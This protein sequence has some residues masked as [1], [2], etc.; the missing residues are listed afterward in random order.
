MLKRILWAAAL[1]V[2][3]AGMA[4]AEDRKTLE[5]QVH[6]ATITYDFSTLKRIDK[7]RVSIISHSVS[8]Q[9]VIDYRMRV[10][11]RLYAFCERPVGRY[12]APQEIMGWG[13]ASN[14]ITPVRV[15]QSGPIKSISWTY[16]YLEFSYRTFGR[17]RRM[18]Q[19]VESVPCV[20]EFPVAGKNLEDLRRWMGEG[21]KNFWVFDCK[22]SK[23][24]SV[25]VDYIEK[26]VS[27]KSVSLIR[28]RNNRYHTREIEV[29]RALAQRS[30]RLS[31]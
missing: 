8:D 31:K 16:P 9:D 7:N 20:D 3:S 1:F 14:P 2:A 25:P 18:A 17:E 30:A 26:G 6:G 27:P 5:F 23:F 4:T 15:W 22:N 24:G 21:K 28:F 12:R 13:R 29:C 11:V 10:A 19:M